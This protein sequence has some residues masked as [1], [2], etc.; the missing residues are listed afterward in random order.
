MI[1]DGDKHVFA[2]AIGALIG[3]CLAIIVELA[4]IVTKLMQI[5]SLL[6]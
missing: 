4:V 1:T 5:I 2:A 6:K 3:A